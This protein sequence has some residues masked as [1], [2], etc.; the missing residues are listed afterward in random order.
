MKKVGLLLVGLLCISVSSLASEVVTNDSGQDAT[1]LRVV[2]SESV[3]ITAFGDTLMKV[4][5]EG[6]A[7]EFVFSG[8]TVAAWG[9]HWLSWTP[10]PARIISHEW[11]KETPTIPENPWIMPQGGTG[12]VAEYTEIFFDDFDTEEPG[13][14]SGLVLLG[15]GALTGD[16]IEPITGQCSVVG[17]YNGSD[18][19]RA[20]LRSSPSILPLTPKHRYAV[21]FDYIIL[22]APN[23]GFEIMFYSPQG[24]R[25][26]HWLPSI[27]I[28]G[29]VG[30]TGRAKLTNDLLD[31][32]DYEVRWN[33]VS[34]GAIL[35]DNIELIDETDGGIVLTEDCEGTTP[36]L[37]PELRFGPHGTTAMIEES[38]IRA[39][40]GASILLADNGRISSDHA[41][42]SILGGNSYIVK[43]DYRI[44]SPSVHDKV[45]RIW[46]QTSG[47]SADVLSTA[48]Y[49]QDMFN[50]E[51]EEGKYSVGIAL[52]GENRYY[53]NIQVYDGASVAID[54]LRILK[55]SSV[56]TSE[57]P[58]HWLQIANAPFPRLGNY[59]MGTTHAM[60]Y[61]MVEGTHFL[62]SVAE[63][64]RRAAFSDVLI[65]FAMNN[66]TLDP[67]FARR[68]RELNP[69]IVLLPYRLAGGQSFGTPDYSRRDAAIQIETE[70]RNGI[71]EKWIM[72]DASGE[73]VMD[74]NW[75]FN[76]K[77]NIY[78]S[79]PLV[80][81][82]TF[83]DYLV[84]YIF[85][86]VLPSGLWDGIYFD[87]LFAR[88]NPHIPNW[89]DRNT[90]DF[91]I[92]NNG[93]R[94]ETPAQ[95]SDMTRKAAIDVL[96][97]IRAEVD[98]HALIVG[99][100]GPA[101]QRALAPYVNGFLFEV[102]N[103]AWCYKCNGHPSEAGWRRALDDYLYMDRHVQWPAIN[104]V[105]GSGQTGAFVMPDRAYAKP[106]PEDF[107]QHRLTLGTA[108]LGNGFYEYDLFEGRSAPYWFDEYTVNSSGEA[109]EDPAF[110]GYLGKALADAEE[111][112]SP[113]RVIWN[114]SFQHH[115]YPQEMWGAP[116]A[117]I[118]AGSLQL[119]N[120]G[121][122]SRTYASAGTVASRVRLQR[123][124][125]YVIESNWRIVET[126]DS[127]ASI[128]MWGDGF[129]S[130][131]YV[132]PGMVS[133]DSGT[134]RFPVVLDSGSDF[135]LGLVI[136]QGAGV[137]A[138]D[139]MR[140]L[141]GGAGPW[142]RD[143]ENGFVLINPLPIPYVFTDSELR[144]RFNR[145]GIH[146]ID[147][148]QDRSVNNGKSVTEGLTLEPFD[149]IILLADPIPAD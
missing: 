55:Q 5:P 121:D 90:L 86:D 116:Q 134:V 38:G 114:Q 113:E 68:L 31:Y 18:Q 3:T 71:A 27:N 35:I 19:Y 11:L 56:M 80:N 39:G 29:Q 132:L 22:E 92:N 34:N 145:T 62:Y 40:D 48:V 95:I 17:R 144:G 36:A 122:Y 74:L 100:T 89:S 26:G 42:L 24:G 2:F 61:G 141:E 21:T 54:N 46:F 75:T 12:W 85:Q 115:A 101:P 103:I 30:D 23:R 59:L 78:E 106:R 148:S 64:E 108:L 14:T 137:V 142:R 107:R 77:M 149:A 57:L 88:I 91:D 60:A 10:A 47:R 13:L 127:Y 98:N 133:G 58:E 117:R 63:I 96:T 52:P 7:T 1:G 105:E 33:V 4:D 97:K 123:G 44:L 66:Q 8:G 140:I 125:T 49:L 84:Q 45:L 111:L 70:F 147:G 99:N 73:D 128:S 83:N 72:K 67:A 82:Q 112:L 120:W 109:I 130:C 43:F 118:I 102:F 146:R 32:A 135:S 126:L 6:I 28:T 136:G 41:Q 69:N 53:L 124:K 87:N 93:L 138:F 129:D 79:C 20:Y 104:V 94:D 65:G 37:R 16:S 139:N 143:F 119:S 81:G 51:P 9:S 25:A 50:V 76:K 110:K 131:M 15:I